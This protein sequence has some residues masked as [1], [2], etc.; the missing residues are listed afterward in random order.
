LTKL[1]STGSF[2][3]GLIP[4]PDVD[5]HPNGVEDGQSFFRLV[6]C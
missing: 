2:L 6:G 3:A 5:A 1:I 4:D